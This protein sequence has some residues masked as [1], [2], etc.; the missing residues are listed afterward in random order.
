MSESLIEL[1]AVQPY[2]ELDDYRTVDAFDAKIAS[3]T[4][5]IAAARERDARGRFRHPGVVVFPEHIGTF[6]SIA[7]YGDLARQGDDVDAVLRRVV[8]RNPLRLLA[9]MV[10]YAT[11]SPACAVLLMESPKMHRAYRAAFRD[12]ARRLEATVV[13]GSIILPD[14][15]NGADAETMR[16]ASARLYN[17]SY[18]FAPDGRCIDVTRKVNLVPTLEDTLPLVRGAADAIAAIATPCGRVGVMICYDGFREPHTDR[19]PGFCPLGPHLAAAGVQIVAQPSANPWPWNGR[20]VFCEA[21]EEQLRREQWLR[22]GLFS[23][24]PDMPGVR[25]VVN[26]QLIGD[27]LGT[28]FD[29]RSYV[30]E[31]S[32]DGSTTILAAAASELLARDSEEILVARV[33]APSEAGTAVTPPLRRATRTS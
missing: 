31:R 11:A 7:G 13:A 26:P 3:L 28:R 30:F 21:G 12:T 22:E 27:L 5:R 17:L 24:L 6:L 2:M 9:S 32:A 14:N 1:V 15:A 4:D 16:P 33:A 25:Y 18:T 29:G 10:R 20:W 23:Q 19:E 8:L